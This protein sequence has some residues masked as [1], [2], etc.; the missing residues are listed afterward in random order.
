MAEIK[1]IDVLWDDNPIDITAEANFI[2][3]IANKLRGSYMPDKY[4]DV[5]IPFTILRRFE[6]TL[7]PTKKQVV[8]EFENDTSIPEKS[9]KKTSG[10][11]FYNTSRFTLKELCND[12]DHIA[13]NIKSYINGFSANV[14]DIMKELGM[15]THIDKMN[16]D[17]CLYS[18]VKAFSELDLNPDTF[19]SIKM[20]YIFENLIGRF[21]QNASEG[22]FYTGRDIIKT[23]VSVLISEGC[24]DVFDDHKIITVCDQACGTGGMLSTAYS[25]LKHLN[26]T[27]DVRLFGQEFMGVSYAMG[28]AEM[29]I[30]GQNAENFRHADT[31]K[32]DCFR[33]TKMRFVI[34]N[35]PFGTPW[36]GENAKEGQEEAVKE[37]FAKGELGRWGAGL[38]AGG[39]SQMLFL[40][41]AIAKMDKTN[42]R[43]AI[44]S[45]GSPLFAGGTSSGESQI[46]RWLLKNDYV[47]AII[48]F[49]TDLFYNTGLQ[50]YV[51]I[52]SMNKRPARRGKVQ[53]ID[54]SNI[55]HKL[56]KPL[57]NKK[58]ELTAEDRKQ[59]TELYTNFEENELCQIYDNDDFL[60][61]EYTI[62]QPLQRSYGITEERIETMLNSGALNSLYDEAK[63]FEWENSEGKL[64]D[65]D[66]K[67]LDIFRANKSVYDSILATLR[68]NISDKVYL[69]KG[70]FE[71]VLYALLDGCDK[72]LVGKVVDG[73]SKMD[74][75]AEIQRDKKG[76]ILYDKETKDI[77]LVP[78]K[79][80]IDDY[81]KAEVLPHV[82]D[83]QWFFEENLAA[84]KPVIR[85]G[86]E[87]PF[88][89]FFYKYKK[90]IDSEELAEQFV[91]LEKNVA[92]ITQT[93]TKGTKP[94][95]PVKD[96][97]IEWVGEVPEHWNIMP[98]KYVMHKIKQ[99]NPIY[100]GEDILSLTM[101][102]V[103]VRDLEAGGKMPASFDGYQ[104]LFKD[105]LLMC[106]FDIDVTPR[107]I[108]LI[109][110][111]GLSSPAYSQFVMHDNASADYFYYYYLMVD[112][113][114]ELLHMAKNLR[115]SLT[116]DQLGAIAVPVPPIP[117]QKEIAAFL[118]GKCSEIDGM[119]AEKKRQI[120]MLEQYK[121]SLIFEYVTGKKQVKEN[122]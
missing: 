29:L 93:L 8:E 81:M 4:A 19:D 56:R 110:N 87:I 22:Q 32:E 34:E 86:A 11:Q 72:K 122:E 70:S 7:E 115:H 2:W 18:V 47:E 105:N 71:K 54:A 35:P 98:N 84:K 20:G 44:M 6:C 77:E 108:G 40:Q 17:G 102:G 75:A 107:C 111:E 52:L 97:G 23:L 79:V 95:G 42:G 12:P 121:K 59:I 67:K 64:S 120:D 45:D 31:F 76:N 21:Y 58:Y 104:K 116:E 99:I 68:T 57:G 53:L 109:K 100:K 25:Y 9:L 106:L 43:A 119:I 89:R 63:V 91:E 41:S 51:W 1:K 39:D 112:Y 103:I 16:K 49:S 92:A 61:R 38:P 26:P 73:L 46:R 90:P 80:D 66:K 36:S 5:I 10:Y 37:E 55:Y 60:Y 28:L 85:T 30:K 114:K 78:F 101:N 15:N 118:D 113:T 82:P 65:K 94:D 88:T 50:T 74:K 24:D 48:A 14:Q 33:N 27:A 96:S 117:E 3:S 83:A 13:D 69:D 62:M